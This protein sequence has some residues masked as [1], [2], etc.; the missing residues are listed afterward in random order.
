MNKVSDGNNILKYVLISQ[1]RSIEIDK[2]IIMQQKHTLRRQEI[3][4]SAIKSDDSPLNQWR[5]A[6]WIWIVLLI[7]GIMGGGL[8]AIG[9]IVA[10]IMM[11]V[12]QVNQQKQYIS[13]V[14]HDNAYELHRLEQLEKSA[15]DQ[16]AIINNKYDRIVQRNRYLLPPFH[17]IGMNRNY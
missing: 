13:Q 15:T 9:V 4:N 11:T 12:S 6:F 5:K 17:Q 8:Y 16:I 10:Y 1:D 3:V 14:L 7:I 2:L